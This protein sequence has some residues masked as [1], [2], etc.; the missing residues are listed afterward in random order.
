MLKQLANSRLK[1]SQIFPTPPTGKTPFLKG[2]LSPCLQ[3]GFAISLWVKVNNG[4]G[5]CFNSTKFSVALPKNV[6]LLH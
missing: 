2:V 1:Q 5:V 3:Q 6:K 4:I